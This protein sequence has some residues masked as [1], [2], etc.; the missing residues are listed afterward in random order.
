MK[1]R[2]SHLF[3]YKNFSGFMLVKII[4]IFFTIV[5]IIIFFPHFFRNT[6]VVT[7]ES[8]RI[9]KHENKDMYLIYTE[10]QNGDIRVF[11]NDNSLLEFKMLS[12]DLY[13]GLKINKKY[14]I[15]A[16]GL[17]IPILSSYQNIIKAKGV[18]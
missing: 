17:S 6:Y 5:G 4:I 18:K 8:K 7:I 14:E 11:K 1:K 12:E 13:W 9:I 2:I 10:M 16:Y 15:K 3:R